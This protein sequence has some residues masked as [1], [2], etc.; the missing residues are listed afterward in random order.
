[1]AT[2]NAMQAKGQRYGLKFI[3]GCTTFANTNWTRQ[4]MAKRG[5][6]IACRPG[7]DWNKFGTDLDAALKFASA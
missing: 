7:E 6:W 1:M 5:E 2:V 4:V 3:D